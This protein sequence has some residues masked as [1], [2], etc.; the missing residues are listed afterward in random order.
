M[1]SLVILSIH[2]ALAP[3]PPV[4]IKPMQTK[5]IE[6]PSPGLSS[7]TC[8]TL[9]GLSATPNMMYCQGMMARQVS[10]PV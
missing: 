3:G 7:C 5:V 10:V 2:G 4:E 8:Q 1:S 9:P 6:L